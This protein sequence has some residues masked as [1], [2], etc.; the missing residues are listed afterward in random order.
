[1]TTESTDQTN[2]Q[3]SFYLGC[4][5]N[6]KVT[7][8]EDDG[9]LSIVITSAE[10]IVDPVD[11][12]GLFFNLTDDSQA[13]DLVIAPKTG[14][15]NISG[16]EA[17]ADSV[18]SLS[19]GATL[20]EEYDVGVQFGTTE[21]STE[22]EITEIGFALYSADGK[23]LT[24]D[25]L[26]MS[27]F[28]AAVDTDT[29]DG[30]V[31][32]VNPDGHPGENDLGDPGGE[33]EDPHECSFIIEGE[34]NIEVV[35][36]ELENGDI[37]VELNVLSG[38]DPDATG[39]I[40]DLNGFFF[41]IADE[42]LLDG[43][44]A[45]GEH[46]TGSQFDANNVTN[47]GNGN[48]MNGDIVNDNGAFDGGV[49]IGTQGASGDDIQSTTFT[50]SHPDGLSLDDFEGQD[51][52]LRLTSVGDEDAE[53]REGSLKLVGQ[54]VETPPEDDCEYEYDIDTV[55]ALMGLDPEE[56]ET[57]PEEPADDGFEELVIA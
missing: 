46:V 13:G 26:D 55:M 42:T 6:L 56:A 40:G 25:D 24:L 5:P 51:I 38:D 16:F 14:D 32:T 47:L 19:N 17:T 20:A 43:L 11:I 8:T 29:A 36:T 34:V 35:L 50:L 2:P 10:G 3:T 9:T 45:S 4:D 48:N 23:P 52:G 15:A 7:V 57:P 53:D 30:K 31:M 21:G 1:M 41:D 12:D 49:S 33:P 18:D 54:C 44:S 27:S 28:A 39:S 22:G 37:E